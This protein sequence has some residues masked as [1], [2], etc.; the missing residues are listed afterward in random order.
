MENISGSSKSEL[1]PFRVIFGI[2]ADRNENS[3]L[4]SVAQ[5][6]KRY[7]NTSHLAYSDKNYILFQQRLLTETL[8]WVVKIRKY[9]ESKC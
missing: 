9:L 4:V 3:L 7:V 8:N 6:Y 5:I 2:L 1:D